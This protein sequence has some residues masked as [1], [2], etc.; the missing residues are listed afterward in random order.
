MTFDFLVE[1]LERN[2]NNLK[3]RDVYEEQ[4]SSMAQVGSLSEFNQ[5]NLAVLHLDEFDVLTK[6]LDYLYKARE[7]IISSKV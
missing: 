4:L 2:L 6:N 3:R 5:M 1:G 7:E